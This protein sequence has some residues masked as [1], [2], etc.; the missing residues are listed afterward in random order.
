MVLVNDYKAKD[1]EYFGGL[2]ELLVPSLLHVTNNDS[3]I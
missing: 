1:I 2:L 3:I